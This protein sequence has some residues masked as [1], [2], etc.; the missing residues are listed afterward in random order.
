MRHFNRVPVNDNSMAAR[1]KHP[2]AATTLGAWLDFPLSR[3]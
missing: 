1:Q 2:T 3:R